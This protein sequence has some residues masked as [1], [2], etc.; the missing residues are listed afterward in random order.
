MRAELRHAI[1]KQIDQ[2][3][4]VFKHIAIT[5]MGGD[6]IFIIHSVVCDRKVPL[7]YTCTK[8][9]GGTREYSSL[10]IYKKLP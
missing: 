6:D 1:L 3:I 5:A 8:M 7:F 2:L 10:F 4:K 9:T